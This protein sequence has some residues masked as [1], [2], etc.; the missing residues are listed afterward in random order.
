MAVGFPDRRINDRG[1]FINESNHAG[2]DYAGRIFWWEQN[3][4]PPYSVG[5]F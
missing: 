1:S 4:Q 5:P 3:P 2:G